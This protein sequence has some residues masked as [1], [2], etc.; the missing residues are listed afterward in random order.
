VRR[1]RLGYFVHVEFERG[2]EWCAERYYT[3]VRRLVGESLEFTRLGLP[4]VKRLPE[5]AVFLTR[6]VFRL[7]QDGDSAQ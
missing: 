4:T 1:A 5:S 2:S 7:N 6:R 3:R